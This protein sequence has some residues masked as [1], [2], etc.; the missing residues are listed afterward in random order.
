MTPLR[1]ALGPL[2]MLGLAC[3]ACTASSQP[4]AKAAETLEEGWIPLS[5]ETKT[6]THDYQVELALTQDEQARGLMFR[7][8]MA[9]DE[10]MLFPFDPPRPASFWMKN[11]YL[12]LDMIFVTADGTIESIAADTVPL[13]TSSYRSQGTVAA[14]LELNAGEAARIGAEAGDRVSYELPAR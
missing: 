2:M 6:G 7:Q 4:S 8:E 14:V 10:G 11:T 3:S 9:P 13:A 5:I 1:L 12:P